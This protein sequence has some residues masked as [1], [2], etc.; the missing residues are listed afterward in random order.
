MRHLDLFSGIGGF[1]LTVEEIWPGSEHIF[2]DN[3][4]YCQELLKI[5]LPALN[6][7]SLRLVQQMQECV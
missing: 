6:T 7:Y 1:A 5:R 4:R 3:D 2:C